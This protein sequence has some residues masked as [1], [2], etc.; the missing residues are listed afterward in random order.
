LPLGDA[1]PVL[2]ASDDPGLRGV[3]LRALT[4]EPPAAS[5]ARAVQ[6]A[7][8]DPEL[9]VVDAAIDA[10]VLLAPA[11]T[12]PRVRARASEPDP[13]QALL[14]L[15]LRGEAGDCDVVLAARAESSRRAAAIHALG[16]VGAPELVDAC[17]GWLEDASCGP[18]VGEML[19]A[20]TGADLEDAE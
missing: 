5:H 3:G 13:S 1:I 18:L 16:H 17:L 9:Q 12:W 19:A 2:L 10:G 4:S 7:L 11:A 15:A 20:L 14:R 8:A 6:A